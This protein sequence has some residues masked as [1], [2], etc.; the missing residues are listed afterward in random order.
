[1]RNKDGIREDLEQVRNFN[2]DWGNRISAYAS[3]YDEAVKSVSSPIAQGNRVDFDMPLVYPRRPSSRKINS[4]E[5]KS[6]LTSVGDNVAISAAS[7]NET[8]KQ[9]LSMNESA[10]ANMLEILYSN[11]QITGPP[12]IGIAQYF[13]AA[14]YSKNSN[15]EFSAI[16]IF[17]PSDIA[18]EGHPDLIHSLVWA[19]IAAYQFYLGGSEIAVLEYANKRVRQFRAFQEK[20]WYHSKREVAWV[21][22]TRC[23]AHCCFC[24]GSPRTEN[25]LVRIGATRHAQKEIGLEDI[26][27][28]L[29]FLW[30]KGVRSINLTGGEPL[31][32]NEFE[33]IVRTIH[34]KGFLIRLNTL[35]TN[36]KKLLRVLPFLSQLTIS[37]HTDDEICRKALGMSVPVSQEVKI[38]DSIWNAIDTLGYA[39][40]FRIATCLNGINYQNSFEF[41]EF[42]RTKYADIRWVVYRVAIRDRALV[43]A[44]QLQL[45]DQSFEHFKWIIESKNWK[46]SPVI[47][48]SEVFDFEYF[49]IDPDGVIRSPKGKEYYVLGIL[50]QTMDVTG[51]EAIW[52]RHL[53]FAAN[54]E[55]NNL[56]PFA[57]LVNHPGLADNVALEPFSLTRRPFT[58]SLLNSSAQTMDDARANFVGLSE[59]V[60][61]YENIT[62][63]YSGRVI[64]IN[65]WEHALPTLSIIIPHVS[66]RVVELLNRIEEISQSAMK[67]EAE[68]II[69]FATEPY[70]EQ[71]D[72]VYDA[73]TTHSIPA[74]II[75]SKYN[76]IPNNRNLGI[77]QARGDMVL[78]LD[79]DVRMW[80][81]PIAKAYHA[82]TLYPQIGLVGV[83]TLAY[84][85]NA[86]AIKPKLQYPTIPMVGDSRL[87]LVAT[88]SGD[89]FM[90]RRS[91]LETLPFAEFWPSNA[92]DQEMSMRVGALGY[93]VA[94]LHDNA[95]VTAE[96]LSQESITA[97]VNRNNR[98]ADVLYSHMLFLYFYDKLI[99]TSSYF[100]QFLQFYQ[101]VIIGEL[102][103]K[104]FEQAYR[105]FWLEFKKAVS[106]FFADG[107]VDSFDI[108]KHFDVHNIWFGHIKQYL[109]QAFQKLAAHK[110]DA[111]YF[112]KHLHAPLLLTQLPVFTGP[113]TLAG[114]LNGTENISAPN[115]TDISSPVGFND[116]LNDADLL[117]E[118]LS[119]AFKMYNE[120]G[121]VWAAQFLAEYNI[122]EIDVHLKKALI[123]TVEMLMHDPNSNIGEGGRWLA[124]EFVKQGVMDTAMYEWIMSEALPM[125]YRAN[126]RFTPLNVS[127]YDG[128][129]YQALECGWFIPG[130]EG[131]VAIT[132]YDP[133]VVTVE[134]YNG[135]TFAGNVKIRLK[136]VKDG[137][138]HEVILSHSEAIDTSNNKKVYSW[139]IDVSNYSEFINIDLVLTNTKSQDNNQDGLTE[140][141]YLFLVDRRYFKIIDKITPQGIAEGKPDYAP[142]T[143]LAGKKVG[144]FSVEATLSTKELA[145]AMGGGLGILLGSFLRALPFAGVEFY[146]S[147]P[148]YRKGVSQSAVDGMPTVDNNALLDY[149]VLF[150]GHADEFESWEEVGRKQVSFKLENKEITT[151]VKLV[152]LKVKSSAFPAYVF[153]VELTDDV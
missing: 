5:L 117:N 14:I 119:K 50:T 85:R 27:G 100:V 8:I 115:T 47:I 41:S 35:G 73:L 118:L 56:V 52:Q 141:A 151:Y 150:S 49:Q 42:M 7:I 30:N 83:P 114:D 28:F 33:D 87:Y 57:M 91:I 78:Q 148:V 97:D 71:L 130:D 136:T 80:G 74:K 144:V 105:Q 25:S 109:E 116:R 67:D 121:Y 134:H 13:N 20:I 89:F 45:N 86:R 38:I 108:T 113:L 143:Q 1:M 59:A 92:E 95:F 46:L 135:A 98:Y 37:L 21:L 123:E 145:G 61:Y 131:K 44:G 147:L 63:R 112:K 19:S 58:V 55:T 152:T 104:D 40:D 142:V 36:T 22:T 15:R 122:A 79:D 17:I 146:F 120:L 70:A 29:D 62:D 132:R 65:D 94:Y 76:T 133:L 125:L 12:A 64:T 31:L 39:I 101:V 18:I 103:N 72:P 153:F 81:D 69:I 2:P 149:A 10:A 23:V 68:L 124:D 82:L 66:R 4:E 106:V 111:R 60:S 110:E 84:Q 77:A 51:Y 99:S 138:P 129:L 48:D 137:V 75:F 16:R 26:N 34:E 126:F 3:A 24:W 96:N 139:L 140:D 32:H 107:T 128:K 11:H 102:G 9:L 93:Y 6:F 88:I 127:K 53:D 54:R 43:H 90:A